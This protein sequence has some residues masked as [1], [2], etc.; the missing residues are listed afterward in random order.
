MST[1]GTALGAVLQAGESQEDNCGQ[2][3]AEFIHGI[4]STPDALRPELGCG[5]ISSLQDLG[6]GN[7]VR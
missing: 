3:T 2:C 5:I 7:Y 6:H 1:A 4:D